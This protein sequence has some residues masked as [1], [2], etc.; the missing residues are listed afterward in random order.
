MNAASSL[1]TPFHAFGAN[2]VTIFGLGAAERA[3]R[4]ALKAGLAPVGDMPA[5]GPVIRA[6]LDFA[7]DPA[8]L[9]WV[10]ARPGRAVS[11]AGRI[12]IAHYPDAAST[13]G[14]D[15]VRDAA[16]DA[17]LYNEALRKR[18]DAYLLP[19]VP[20]NAR[21]IEQ[22]S[23]DGAYKGVTDL[24]TLYLWR[25][26]AFHLTRWAAAAR[27]SPNM[28]TVIGIAFCVLAFFLFRDGWFWSGIA[29][30]LVFMVLDTV[31]GKLARCTGTSSAIGNV[32]D[33][34]VDLVHPPF[35]YWAWGVGLAP[36]GQPMAADRLWTIMAVILIGY[37]VQ[38]LVE[39]AFIKSFAG[40]H[41]HVWQRIDSRFR[42]ITARRNPNMV[43]LF[44]ALLAGAPR[45]GLELVA[46][47]TAI[48]CLFHI[49]RLGQAYAARAAGRP[50]TSWL[51]GA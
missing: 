14:L 51:A 12:A 39:G 24:L 3:R 38:R 10:K 41:I 15:E 19:L 30:G 42:L 1:Q 2:G 20:E 21:A 7:W 22:A 32:L 35:W 46:W 44:F 25:G 9:A 49:V 5:S 13:T 48:S 31:D 18:Q 11:H 17:S 50:V 36:W 47:W 8:W 6:D 33:H 16:D 45:L 29:A 23:Y 34:G 27:I 28:V 4:L 40:I 26:I 43:I 37:V